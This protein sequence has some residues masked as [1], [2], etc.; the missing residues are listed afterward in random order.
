MVQPVETESDCSPTARAARLQH[1]RF[2][3]TGVLL[4]HH[5]LSGWFAKGVRSHS[6]SKQAKRAMFWF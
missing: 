5:G 2:N 6:A 3:R 1:Q 4:V